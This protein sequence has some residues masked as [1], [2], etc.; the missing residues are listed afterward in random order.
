MKK[1]LEEILPRFGMPKTVGSDNGPAFI[2]Q[3]SQRVGKFLG[4]DWKLHCAYCPQSSGQVEKIDWTLKET[5]T[6]VF[7]ETSTG[8]V[9]LLPMALFRARNIPYHF[10]LNPFKI[11]YGTPTSLALVLDTPPE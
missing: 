1:I 6:K 8:W 2:C 5:L 10:N 9:V 11:L 3:V 7:L 4:T